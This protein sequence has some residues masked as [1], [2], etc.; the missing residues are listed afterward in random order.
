MKKTITF[1]SIIMSLL[2]FS[3]S[4]IK[5]SD[6]CDDGTY[7]KDTN[8]RNFHN[9]ALKE[10]QSKVYKSKIEYLNSLKLRYTM[11]NHK[12]SSDSIQ[13]IIDEYTNNY[14]NGLYNKKLSQK[15]L[16]K[17]CDDLNK[18]QINY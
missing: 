4:D 15:E 12:E 10:Y 3:C 18:K 8:L 5:P 2:M 13:K 17:I 7:F 1:L 11:F 6:L 9:L 14:K 16:Q